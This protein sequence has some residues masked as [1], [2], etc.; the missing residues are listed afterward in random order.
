MPT[1]KFATH[2]CRRA[3]VS[4]LAGAALAGF[5][6]AA[7]PDGVE[8][9]SWAAGPAPLVNLERRY[10]ADALVLV[11]GLHLLFRENVGGGRVL[12]REFGEGLTRLLEFN[13]FSAP[14]RAAG[15]NR[16]GFI[17]ELVRTSSDRAECIYFGLMTAST[18]ESAE[19][20]RKALH[21]TAK[22]QVYSAI[23]GRIGVAEMETTTA[24]FTAPASVSGRESTELVQR[25]RTAL[26]AAHPK[27][28]SHSPGECCR[29][30][31]YKLAE[32][33][34][35]PDC[36]DGRYIYSGRAYRIHLLRSADPKATAHFRDRNLV[37]APSEVIRVSG[38]VCREAGGKET[39]FRVWI[40]THDERPI[41]L[42]IEYQPKR[43]LRLTFEAVG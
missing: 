27:I 29:P 19:D 14:E 28:E 15:L 18:E 31:L 42:R 6:R 38:R 21:S 3:F 30:F 32:M 1:L 5:C 26:A 35:H 12:W 25:A 33:L 40:P 37:A 11:L 43:Y 7:E 41:P 2:F 4:T 22:E 13:G 39:D 36:N 9:L 24:Q 10:R 23:D 17:R 20:A 16:L 34:Q 8:R